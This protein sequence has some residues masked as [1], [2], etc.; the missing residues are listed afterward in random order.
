[1]KKILLLGAGYA[2]I[3][4]LKELDFNRVHAQITLISN[5][6]YHYNTIL[7]H[8]VASGYRKESVLFYLKDI[9]NKKISIIQDEVQEIREKEVICKNSSYDYDYLIVG[10]GFSSDTFGIKGIREYAKA[11][12]DFDSAVE[13]YNHVD[14]K[15]QSYKKTQDKLDLK[16]VICGGGFSGIELIS[17]LAQEMNK[18][19]EKYSVDRDLIE[20]ICI[21]AMPKIL[22]MFNDELI[23][24]GTS[25]L[26]KQ[27]ISIMTSSKILEVKQNSIIIE[28]S[29]DN[30]EIFAN[31]IIWTAG[32]KGNE[33]IENSPFFNSNRSKVEVN[34]FL[35]PINQENKMDNVFV[36]G[37]CAA[38][39]D[40]SS[41]RF[42]PPT[43]QIATKEGMYLAK[44]LPDIINGN[45]VKEE[46]N[47]I[48]EGTV[49]SLGNGFA[50]ANTGSKSFAG[51]FAYLIKWYLESKW[52]FK[53]GGIKSIFK[54]K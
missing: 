19:C 14:S 18:F 28:N 38:F 23:N 45:D 53:L 34:N 54:A 15:F 16:F 5:K 10:L 36:I 33:V 46:F 24:T 47:F 51:Y 50:L 27:G 3:S 31:T 17:S 52:R 6:D 7:L 41:G 13:I 22:P 43:A 42:Y 4:V 11:M 29:G 35:R 39:K 1:M 21:E 26:K 30:N 49:C 25:R 2:N 9:L 48:S 37:D 32:V 8:E 40:S 12:S 20:L 44:V